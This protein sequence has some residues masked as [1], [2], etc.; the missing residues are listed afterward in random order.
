M[1]EVLRAPHFMCCNKLSKCKEITINYDS[2]MVLSCICRAINYPNEC[3][4]SAAVLHIEEYDH[5]TQGSYQSLTP[6]SF[7]PH[8]SSNICLNQQPWQV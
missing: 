2:V 6:W 8:H 3:R 7:V 1:T 5:A 4:P